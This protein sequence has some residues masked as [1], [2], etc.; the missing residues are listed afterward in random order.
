MSVYHAFISHK[1]EDEPIAR[2][3]KENL[4]R[5][6]PDKLEVHYSG[7]ISFGTGYRQ[8][9]EE[10]LIRSKVL[11]FLYTANEIEDSSEMEI[12]QLVW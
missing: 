10:Y 6:S 11:I 4:E 3:L 8:W 1:S 12:K 9:I 7:E 2:A 5:F